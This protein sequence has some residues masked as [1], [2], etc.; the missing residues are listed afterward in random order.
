ML[1]KVGCVYLQALQLTNDL[2]G[3]IVQGH[4]HCKKSDT[5]SRELDVEI[6]YASRV[7]ENEPL[8]E[9]VVQI[10]KVR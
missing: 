4:F 6:H 10:F 9:T 3:T 5:N 1:R 7:N 2:A 8:G